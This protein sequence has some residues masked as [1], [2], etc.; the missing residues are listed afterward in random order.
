MNLG[1]PSIQNVL[2]INR[3]PDYAWDR[4][5]YDL[6]F[7][8][9]IQN[10]T[11]ESNSTPEHSS[12]DPLFILYTS[13]STGKPKGV[14]HKMGGYLTYVAYTHEIVFQPQSDDIF[15]CTADLGWITGHSY[16]VYGP[17]A[18]GTTTLMY[19]GIPT[20]PDPSRFWKIIE[21]Y[22]VSIFYTS[23]T[24]IRILASFGS[25]FVE[26]CNLRSLRTL[27]SV[28]EPI[29]PEAWK[30]YSRAIGENRCP[31]VDTWWQTETG[32]ILISPLAG[33]TPTLP[34]SASLPLPGIEPKIVSDQGQ[35]IK[36]TSQGNLVLCRSWPGQMT[37]V[38]GEP[39]RFYE[40]YFTQFPGLY[41][42]GDAAHQ[43]TEGFYWIT[44]RTDDVIKI[45]GHRLGSAEVE[46]AC[47]VHPAISEAAA[48]G[49]PDP[50]TGEALAIFAVLKEGQKSSETIEKELTST[51][52]NEIGH[53]ATPKALFWVPGLPKTRSG[54]VM[55]RILKK[56]A[57]HD[58]QKL[59]D[60]SSL[61]DPQIVEQILKSQ[62]SRPAR[63][64]I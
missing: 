35:E 36:D 30:W 49:I 31:I 18:N 22:K 20:Y 62:N 4:K 14:L 21:K 57:I 63:A 53:V 13:G 15:W 33:I 24:A 55:R 43:N 28:G 37:E 26:N 32:G 42:A 47:L 29:N 17:L 64:P 9:L 6:R 11:V 48:V 44:G 12:E 58:T 39:K 34:G 19:E 7:E 8:E 45:S 1:C 60:I 38:F 10:A 5:K 25:Q 61:A 59:G 51:V 46:S 40:T 41:S 27:G 16:V 54:K 50:L 23:P 56:I 3:H 52:R 2:V